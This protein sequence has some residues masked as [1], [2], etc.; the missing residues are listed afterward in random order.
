[1]ECYGCLGNIQELLG[2]GKTL[3]ARRFGESSKAPIIPFGQL[4]E[5]H[6]ISSKDPSR[7]NQIGKK[8]LP[9]FF[10][11]YE[12]IAEGIWKRDILVADLEDFEN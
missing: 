7:I 11:G 12:L 5:Y 6:P 10:L 2:N 3:Y 9:G 1:M 4:I 8:I